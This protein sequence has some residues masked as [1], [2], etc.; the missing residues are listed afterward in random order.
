MSFVSQVLGGGIQ[1]TTNIYNAF[2]TAGYS[3]IGSI[4]SNTLSRVSTSGALTANTL[5]DLINESGSAGFIS[6][7]S[8][9]TN[10]AT[11]R[12]LRIVVTVDGVDRYDYTSAA[13]TTSGNG[14]VLAGQRRAVDS[15]TLPPI[16]YTNSIRVQY[17][18]SVTETGKFTI[19][20]AR[21]QVT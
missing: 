20:L 15:W 10:D 16:A 1:A 19:S 13:I 4:E 5:V 17:A 2:S 18:S 6:Q 11:S 7:L 21:T 8:I 9:S 14:T 3:A 12:T